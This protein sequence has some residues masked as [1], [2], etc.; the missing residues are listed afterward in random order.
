MIL[1]NLRHTARVLRRNTGFTIAAVLSLTLAIGANTAIFS[2]INALLLRDLNVHRPGQL[3]ELAVGRYDGTMPFSYPMFRELG[4]RQRVF[5]DLFAWS[6]DARLNVEI[7]G[8]VSPNSVLPVSGNYYSALGVV[9]LLGQLIAPQDDDPRFG[10]GVQVAVISYEFWR[11]RFGGVPSVLGQQ[12]NIE[13]QP[14]TIIGVTRK[15]FMGMTLGA[16]PDITIPITAYPAV[17]GSSLNF[18]LENRSI[19]WLFVTGQLKDGVT[20]SQA[21]SQLLSFWPEML[22]ATAPT[23]TPGPRRDRFSSMGLDVTS[24]RRGIARD[25]RAQ[26]SRPLYVLWGIVALILLVACVNLASLLLARA[27]ARSHEISIRIAIGASPRAVF[28]QVLTESLVVCLISGALGLGFAYWG[29]N[30]LVM[31]MTQ[32]Y[33]APVL[34]DLRPD[35][36]V[37]AVAFLAA[38]LT[39]ILISVGPT[40]R[41][42]RQDPGS[43]LQQSVRGIAGGAGRSDKTLIV[44]QVALSVVVLL[45]A[46]LFLRTFE[47]LHSVNLGFEKHGVLEINLQPRPGG[48]QNADIESYRSLLIERIVALPGVRSATF[49]DPILNLYPWRDSVSAMPANANSAGFLTDQIGIWPG[50]L[51]TLGIE[52]IRGRDFSVMDD[53]AHPRVGVISRSL[54]ERL[55]PNRDALGQRIRFGVLP[56]F[57]NIEVIGVAADVRLFD[58][59]EAAPL[60]LYQPCLQTPDSGTYLDLYVRINGAR[61]R[62]TSGIT[63]EVSSFGHEYVVHTEDIEEAVNSTLI[64]ERAVALLSGFFAC[65]ALLLAAIGLYGLVAYSVTRRRREIGVRLALGAQRTNVLWIVFRDAIVLVLLGVLVGIPC[66]FAVTRLISTMLFGVSPSDPLTVLV[67][68]F[69]LVSVASVAA[70]FPARRASVTDP[71]VALRTE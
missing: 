30:L 71:V 26:F 6:S 3:V 25:L 17:S 4:H 53:S 28:S 27:A 42:L 70:Y 55:F 9:P 58:I 23:E 63:R 43:V 64:D 21:R 34:L 52:I 69:L 16:P 41:H 44:I 38:I 56:Q 5:S 22:Q 48:Y 15:W 33:S 62:I 51:G 40:W 68:C 35:V 18:N 13:N 2:L 39:G 10:S 65:L 49:G 31:L 46:G 1:H 66:A 36:R 20:I 57:Q 45:S 12:I 60:V 32:N 61:Q 50:F 54:A 7:N 11:Q 29:S 8:G 59:H 67:V 37:C 24:A 19:L 14:F 47:K